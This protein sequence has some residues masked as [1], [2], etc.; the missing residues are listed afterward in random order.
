MYNTQLNITN[1][2]ARSNMPMEM[3]VVTKTSKGINH[4]DVLNAGEY[5]E[6]NTIGTWHMKPMK[7]ASHR[8]H[9]SR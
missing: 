8:F 9:N 6:Y 2:E 3:S 5:L 7:F 1:N 4:S